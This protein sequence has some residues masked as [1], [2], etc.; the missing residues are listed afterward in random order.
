MPTVTL[1][2]VSPREFHDIDTAPADAVPHPDFPG[3]A[4]R[5]LDP[6]V[7]HTTT[8]IIPDGYSLGQ[9][10]QTVEAAWPYH[11]DQPPGWAL[12]DDPVLQM[13]VQHTFGLVP[14]ADEVTMLVTNGCL[15]FA[16]YALG[17]PTGM[18]VIQSVAV[19]QNYIAVSAAT[20]TPAAADTVLSG[21][22]TTSGGGLIRGTAAFSHTA[23]AT[24]YVLTTVFTANGSDTLPV[25]IKAAA[26]FT[27]AWG[28]VVSGVQT[29]TGTN[30]VTKSA[31]GLLNGQAL[32][33]TVAGASGLTA[34]TQVY[35]VIGKTTN[36]FQLATT[37]GGAAV[38]LSSDAS[39]VSYQTTG[40]MLFEAN[41][42]T[43]VTLSASGDNVTITE[44]VT[45]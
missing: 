42:A 34:S 17:S 2:N 44:T 35:Y 1:G 11:S 9:A 5:V 31:H 43:S 13:L 32:V 25:T 3:K 27:A 36:T 45:V 40:T 4:V 33:I 26:V 22:I 23:A 21:E 12:S 24:T 10:I 41:L 6:A 28:T 37:I 7:S 19:N 16:S 18:P 20:I 15:D 8:I 38:A 39:G 30:L 29:T 14:P